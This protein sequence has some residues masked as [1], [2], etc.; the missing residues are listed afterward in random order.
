MFI[1]KKDIRELEGLNMKLNRLFMVLFFRRNFDI[2]VIFL[3][4]SVS[5][6]VC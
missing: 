3:K 4:N 1:K 2:K 5:D 6:S